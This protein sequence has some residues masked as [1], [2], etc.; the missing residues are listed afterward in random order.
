M[1]RL[2]GLGLASTLVSSPWP[3]CS[4]RGLAQPAAQPAS[5]G[6][7]TWSG[8]AGRIFRFTSPTGKVILTNPFTSNPDSPIKPEDI[9]TPT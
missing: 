8:S 7:V 1:R 4:S 5:T 6:A 2:I 9:D 3:P